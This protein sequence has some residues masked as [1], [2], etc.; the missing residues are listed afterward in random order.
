LFLNLSAVP[1]ADLETAG[2]FL[3]WVL[4]LIRQRSAP[5]DEFRTT[6][7]RVVDHL[8]GMAEAERERWLLFLSYIEAM[9]YHDRERSEREALRE[10]ILRAIRSDPRRREVE[11]QMQTIA[12]MLRE[13]GRQAGEL[14]S[15]QQILVR[16]LRLRFGRVPR[17]VEQ[18]IRA[19]SDIARL[20]RWLD[21]LVTA[22]TLGDVGISAQADQ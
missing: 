12:D 18:I 19:T 21:N 2:G 9:I 22:Q 8:E 3:G 5:P 17:P 4:E 7:R 20:D 10:V 14:R 1:A 16:H 13:E 6:T 15:H 11:G